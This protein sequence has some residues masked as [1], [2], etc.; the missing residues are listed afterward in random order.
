MDRRQAIR[1]F[2]VDLLAVAV[3][4]P[5]LA[6]VVGSLAPQ[7]K[8]AYLQW[9]ATGRGPEALW[10]TVRLASVAAATAVAVAWIFAAAAA[11]LPGRLAIV[12]SLLTCLPLL[13]PSSLLGTAWIAA[14]GRQGVLAR[15]LHA[16]LGVRVNVYSFAAAAGALAMRYFGIATVILTHEWRRRLG[17]AAAERVFH[18]P[19]ATSAIR[20]RLAP[21]VGPTAAAFLVVM[22]FSM[23]D[24]ILPGMLLVSTYGTQVLIQYQTYLSSAGATALSAPMALVGIAM[25]AAA[26]LLARRRAADPGDARSGP[27]L[28]RSAAATVCGGLT[29]AAVLVA[30]L[31]APVAALAW[32]AGSVEALWQAAV[33]A[34]QEARRT[35][36]LAC[37]AGALTALL[38]A[39]LAGHWAR[40]RREGRFTTVPVV[41][42]NLTVPASLPAIGLIELTRTGMLAGLD[43]T[44]WPLVLAYLARFIPVGT[45]LLYAVWRAEDDGDVL[46]ARVYR[47]SRWAVI[48]HILW[49]K[50][51]T[52]ILAVLVLSAL[53]AA[54]EL[55]ASV[56]LAA[57]GAS[58]LGVR[59]ETMIHTAPAWMFSALALDVL[60]LTA[61]ALV[62]L[63]AVAV[64]A[65]KR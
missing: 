58:T 10:R 39:V 25:L 21:A 11:R 30:A 64:R 40:C 14:L 44:N 8:G 32:R 1:G 24:H 28:R 29:V 6:A 54:T 7:S 38:S 57:P 4:L 62:V 31:A 5:L 48:R 18:I 63:G 49:P 37:L 55:E 56:L 41:L 15:A 60:L 65:V 36:E 19:R 22:L 35:L 12:A 51:R 23:N 16:W 61:P 9:W 2:C 59:L 34:K 46:A 53:L 13:V 20:L 3:V 43:G 45:L 17:A 50:R 47:M 52:A 42:I 27:A 26:L 33:E